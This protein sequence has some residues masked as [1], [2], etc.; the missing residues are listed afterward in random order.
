MERDKVRDEIIAACKK[1]L[2][3]PT[4]W[5]VRKAKTLLDGLADY[6]TAE[7]MAQHEERERMKRLTV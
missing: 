5:N 4:R 6:D 3:D 1:L 2:D 7:S